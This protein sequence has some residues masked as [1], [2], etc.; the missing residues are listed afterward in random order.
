LALSNGVSLS[1]LRRKFASKRPVIGAFQRGMGTLASHWSRTQ[2]IWVKVRVEV[3]SGNSRGIVGSCRGS[4]DYPVEVMSSRGK[5]YVPYL[6]LTYSLVKRFTNKSYRGTDADCIDG[7]KSHSFQPRASLTAPALSDRCLP[8]PLRLFFP[9][10]GS[11]LFWLP[12]TGALLVR[13]LHPSNF[14]KN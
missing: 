11:S 8:V 4:V 10:G 1:Q 5:V 13:T 14:S 12:S 3:T 6:S 9:L 7:Y 2:P